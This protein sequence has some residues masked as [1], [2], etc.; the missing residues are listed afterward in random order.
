MNGK[1]F[2][3][4]WNQINV[5]GWYLQEVKTSYYCACVY[6]CV[7]AH[8]HGGKAR[9]RAGLC[10]K[11]IKENKTRCEM[12]VLHVFASHI[13]A[14]VDVLYLSLCTRSRSREE[15]EKTEVER[16]TRTERTLKPYGTVFNV[17]L[18]MVKFSNVSTYPL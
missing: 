14:F 5:T 9:V 16:Y 13:W 2:Q 12:F 8:A 3:N 7:R 4:S 15:G 11:Y 6:A 1:H 17:P 18:K 10:V